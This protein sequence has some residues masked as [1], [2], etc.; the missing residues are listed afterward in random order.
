MK[1]TK[2]DPWRLRRPALANALV[3]YSRQGKLVARSWPRPRGKARSPAQQETQDWFR[4]INKILR[5]AAPSQQRMAIE[6]TK[7]TGL[8]PRDL[9]MK[10]AAGGLFSLSLPDGT[11]ITPRRKAIYMAGFQGARLRLNSNQSAPQGSN[12]FIG[13]D[14]PDVDTAGMWDVANPDRLTIPTGVNLVEITAGARLT[15]GS[16]DVF[17]AIR[18]NDGVD[19]AMVQTTGGMVGR[20]AFT[21]GPLAVLPGQY[22]RL[23]LF[24]NSQSR[25]IEAA[26]GTWFAATITTVVDT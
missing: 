4:D 6:A 14:A 25:T 18:R 13:W 2:A 7:G 20:V 10:S 26:T 22:F 21:T 1:I 24:I 3:V 12:L 9:L 8:Y 17:Y 16:G 15:S 19:V 5:L 11:K 23:R